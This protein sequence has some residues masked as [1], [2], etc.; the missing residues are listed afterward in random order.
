VT[1]ALS[2]AHSRRR[3]RRRPVIAGAATVSVL[4]GLVLAATATGAATAGTA[5]PVAEGPI[6]GAGAAG[7]VPDRYIV[8]LKDRAAVVRSS[9]ADLART[10][11]GQV[12]FTYENALRGFSV[13]MPERQARRLA[14]DPRVDFV[15]QVGVARIA[16][17]QNNPPWGLDRIDQRDRPLSST[18]TYPANAG[19]GVTVYVLDTGI[20]ATHQQFSG[21][22]G[23]G[24][25]FID[26]D[27]NPADCNGHGTHVAGTAVGT[28]YGVAK[29]ARVVA[30]R[31]LDCAGSGPWDV[32]IAGVDWVTANA[33][34]PAVANMS[35]GGSG[36]QSSLEAAVRRS[37][38]SGVPYALAAG[39]NGSDACG[40]TPARVAEAITVG[41]S[42]SSDARHTGIGPSNFGTCLDLFAPGTSVLSAY[43]TG[44]TATS[45]LTG[46]SM[47]S[48]HVAGA[49]ALYLGANPS[50]TPQ[51]VRDALVSNSSTGKLTNIGTGSPNR[52]LYMGFITGDPGSAPVITDPGNQTTT[53]NTAVNLQLQASGGTAPY[54]WSASGL[55]TGLSIN[56][57][58]G[59]ISGTPTVTGTSNV[60][61]TV[62]DAA[63]ET[64]TSSFT[65]TVT[66]SGGSCG[67]HEFTVNGTL[68]TG[69]SQFHPYTSTLS[70]T[71]R[72]N[73]C[74]P[75]GTDF[76]LYLQKWNGFSWV[77]VA[78]GITPG[79]TE[80]INYTGTAGQYRYRVHA[81]SGSGNYTLGYTN[82]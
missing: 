28:T 81:Y 18:Y 23:T 68:A 45:T 8:T 24:R 6:R 41:N 35:L 66:P 57:S 3:G 52:L 78:Q 77:V 33:V 1:T 74:G 14:A 5:A 26:N 29:R 36:S 39:N 21:R 47:A 56:S 42:N 75:A 54:S 10:Y 13:V 17:T 25:D 19:S 2:A 48:P 67:T 30:V 34:K 37:I 12:K 58:T 15:E 27:S 70:G 64:D 59:L 76:D 53:V 73:L 44:D 40:F 55:P 50:A 69:A 43:H 4:A 65:W 46:T 82:P 9:A 31:V 7:A 79:N 51:Q 38:G 80:S 62:T 11:G 60:T 32:V 16:D 63:G 22:V 71:H 20:R 61:V 72:A 49:A